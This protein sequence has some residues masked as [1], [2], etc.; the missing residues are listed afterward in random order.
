MKR[1]AKHLARPRIN[2]VAGEEYESESGNDWNDYD[3]SWFDDR[4]PPADKTM[5]AK[6]IYQ[7]KRI[8]SHNYSSDYIKQRQNALDAA[9]KNYERRG[10]VA[11]YLSGVPP[12]WN[13][14]TGLAI[15]RF[16]EKILDECNEE[17][18]DLREKNA[19]RCAMKDA[20]KKRKSKYG[21]GGQG[22]R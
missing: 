9:Q 14:G 19:N 5:L 21:P 3:H 16:N 7:I 18:R 22:G 17:I 2:P 10:E 12:P 15:N 20:E 6:W 1:R 13:E 4:M 11:A 8:K